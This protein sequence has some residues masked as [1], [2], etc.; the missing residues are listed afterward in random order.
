MAYKE[1]VI[2]GDCTLYLGDC[3]DTVENVDEWHSLIS[4]PPYGM[5]FVSNHRIQRHKVIKNDDDVC[6]LQWCCELSASHSK[7]IFCRWD[8]LSDV[9]RPKSFITW[10]KNNHSMG[11]L[12][13]EHARKTEGILFY[14]G[15]KH[16]WPNGRPN[17]V[18]KNNRTGNNLHPTEKPVDLMCQVCAWTSGTIIDPFMGSGSTLVAA[19]KMR[20]KAIGIEIDPDYFL[21][22]V[23]RVRNEYR[24]GDLFYG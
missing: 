2:I 21:I 7:Y 17:D 9:P 12:E 6:L 23:E 13:H 16:N 5:G 10:V 14:D 4:D 15:E 1:K 18:V 11:D 19:A 3:R 24:Q 20:R 22:A 8:N